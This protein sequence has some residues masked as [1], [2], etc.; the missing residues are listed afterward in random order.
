MAVMKACS[1]CGESKPPEAFSRNAR[2]ADGLNPACKACRNAQNAAYRA[3][4]RDSI[5]EQ[6][7]TA[8]AADKSAQ[9]EWN[10][11]WRV[12]NRATHRLQRQRRRAVLKA[13]SIDADFSATEMLAD[14]AARGLNGCSYC[15]GDF[16]SIDHIVPLNRGGQHQLANLAPACV[17]CNSSKRDS[18]LSEWLPGHKQ[19][20][21]ADEM[22]SQPA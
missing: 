2:M 12:N 16:E 5:V 21:A 11:A 3:T 14:W 22:A 6:K 17:R 19:R 18:L 10:R 8:Y 13:A 15:P 9:L 7:R 1:K 20:L 4:H